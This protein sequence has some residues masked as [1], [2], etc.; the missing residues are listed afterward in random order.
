MTESAFT[1]SKKI[2]NVM[3][4]KRANVLTH[5]F[6]SVHLIDWIGHSQLLV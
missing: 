3:Q 1:I 5:F 4:V 2:K 6:I